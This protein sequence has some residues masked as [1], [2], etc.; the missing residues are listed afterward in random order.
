M[1]ESTP[2]FV[3]LSILNKK[4][5]LFVKFLACLPPHKGCYFGP[6]KLLKYS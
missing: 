4:C 2:E 5:L 3:I 6:N 1:R